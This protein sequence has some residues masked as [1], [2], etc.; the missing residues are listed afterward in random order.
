MPLLQYKQP[1]RLGFPYG[2]APGLDPGHV[3]H[4]SGSPLFSAI[5]LSNGAPLNLIT[6][7][8]PAVPSGVANLTLNFNGVI[9][10]ILGAV[11]GS[12][13]SCYFNGSIPNQTQTTCAGIIFL[14][15]NN[16]YQGIVGLQKGGSRG[17]Y[18][19]NAAGFPSPQLYPA[20]G[21]LWQLALNA[22]HFLIVSILYGTTINYL[23]ENLLTGQIQFV[24]STDASTPPSGLTN[25]WMIDDSANEP[26]NAP[27]GV[28]CGC[29]TNSFLNQSQM[30][31]WAADPWSYWY[32]RKKYSIVRAAAPAGTLF[33]PSWSEW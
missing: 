18:I 15:I 7:A 19:H 29:I 13:Q 20:A 8:Y 31:Q 6:S 23:A 5:A 10:N 26:M 11:P 17:F 9:G 30:M 16:S 3:A 1:N 25:C 32:P 28:A 24:S 14:T 2:V 33:R 21:P 27:G 12:G 4:S 22:P